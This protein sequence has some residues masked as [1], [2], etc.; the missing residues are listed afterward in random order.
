VASRSAALS[1]CA[2][3]ATLIQCRYVELGGGPGE[4]KEDSLELGVDGR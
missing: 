2:V 4:K 3:A 1:A